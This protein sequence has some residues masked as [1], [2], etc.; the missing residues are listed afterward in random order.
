MAD[1]EQITQR[2]E[3]TVKESELIEHPLNSSYRKIVDQNQLHKSEY[4]FNK[5]QKEQGY[6]S[7]HCLKGD[8]GRQIKWIE[9]GY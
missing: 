3:S 1:L 9:R 6:Q 7:N 8:A 5:E 4:A 2:L